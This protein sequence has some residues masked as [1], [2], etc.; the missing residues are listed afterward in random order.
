MNW[1]ELVKRILLPPICFL[2]V[3]V[4]LSA[5]GL[6]FVFIKGLEN[7]LEAIWVYVVSFYALTIFCIAC[8]TT[9]PEYYKNIKQKVYENK[10]ANQY[11]TDVAFKTQ[12]TLYSSLLINVIYVAVNAVSA[13]VYET[14]WF[15][16]FAVYYAIMAIM[17]FLLV[18]YIG[19]NYLGESRL[20]E[21]KRARFC[22]YILLTVNLILSAVVLMMLYFERGF[23]YQGFLIYVMAL[24]TFYITTTAVIDLVKYRK[25]HSP[26]MSISK[27]IKLA[28][29]LFSMLFLETAMYAQFGK[30][31]PEETK[32]IMIMATGAGI[33]VIVVGMSVYMIVRSTKELKEIRR[34]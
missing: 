27:V 20:G 21:L 13:Y 12:V 33:S 31:T 4:F 15:G 6:G 11:L 29:A 26:I 32:R 19:R 16:I 14:N 9:F 5:A 2:F 24:Y 8:G 25:Y 34:K 10:Y 30:E 22:A 23:A 3:L 7:S 18:R 1:K 17:R 28:S